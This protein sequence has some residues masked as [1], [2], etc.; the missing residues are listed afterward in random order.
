RRT[1]Q[2]LKIKARTGKALSKRGKAQRPAKTDKALFERDKALSPKSD[3]G[4]PKTRIKPDKLLMKLTKCRNIS[5]NKST[6]TGQLLPIKT[7]KALRHR[8]VPQRT[9]TATTKENLNHYKPSEGTPRQ[10]RYDPTPS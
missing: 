1:S 8:K 3:K 9:S 4:T 5:E 7:S 2:R 6:A 10:K